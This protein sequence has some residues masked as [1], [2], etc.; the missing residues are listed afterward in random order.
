MLELD[1]AVVPIPAGAINF[2][3]LQNAEPDSEVN[4]TSYSMGTGDLSRR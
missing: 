3:I 2:A 1:K 4:P